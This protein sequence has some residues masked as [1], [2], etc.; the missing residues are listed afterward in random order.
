MR[1]HDETQTTKWV[2]GYSNTFL[3]VGL[4]VGW[5]GRKSTPKKSWE[6]KKAMAANTKR[7]QHENPLKNKI[8]YG[9]NWARKEEGGR[10][11]GVCRFCNWGEEGFNH[12]HP[13]FLSRQRNTQH[14]NCRRRR[15]WI[16]FKCVT[17]LPVLDKR[18]IDGKFSLL[19]P[20]PSPSAIW[21][22]GAATILPL[23]PLLWQVTV[24]VVLRSAVFLSSSSPAP[25]KQRGEGGD[26][27]G[28]GA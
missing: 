21:N 18:Q 23:P 7:I 6:E 12:C 13:T 27:E 24:Q 2:Y 16:K 5:R 11:G 19:R 3:L 17:F 20:N 25:L 9:L 14:A 28:R 15:K 26:R 4:G 1:R 22:Y 10:K 8:F